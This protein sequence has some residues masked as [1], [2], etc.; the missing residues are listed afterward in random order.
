MPT[1][2]HPSKAERR[3]A[4]RAQALAIK[5]KQEAADRRAKIITGSVLGVVV[6][7]VIGLVIFLF[8]RNGANEAA[9]KVDDIP[10]AEVTTVPAGATADGGIP[11]GA[12]R[13]AGGAATD[14]APTVAVYVDYMCPYCGQFESINNDGIEAMLTDGTANLVVHPISLLDRYSQGTDFSTRAASASAWVADRA[15]EQWLAFHEALFVNQPA[16]NTPGLTDEEIAAQATAAG[17][18]ADVAEGIAS[19]EARRTFGQWVLSASL[20]ALDEAGIEGTPAIVIDGEQWQ[21]DWSNPAALP[22][23]VADAAK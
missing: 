3:D 22:Q 13:V 11:V 15:P 14:G 8:V 4:A 23:A 5:Q 12:D 1:N 10:L 20:F 6:A 18:P 2:Q 17:V 9:T 7:V 19:G 21:G 16:E